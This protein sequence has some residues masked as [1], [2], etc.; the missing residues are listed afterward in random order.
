MSIVKELSLFLR[1]Q[2]YNDGCFY[3]IMALSASSF[4]Y[5]YLNS[6]PSSLALTGKTF[7]TSRTTAATSPSKVLSAKS[8]TG[9]H[10]TTNKT[11][12]TL[13]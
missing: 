1:D 4:T 5:S 10:A 9:S 13:L 12:N 6:K 3:C 8:G 7:C 2:R 11:E